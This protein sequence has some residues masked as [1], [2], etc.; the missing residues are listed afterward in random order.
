MFD[1]S[2]FYDLAYAV[3]Y[4]GIGTAVREG[5]YLLPL[6]N[7]LHIMSVVLVFGTIFIVDLRMIGIMATNRPFTKVATELL[8]W[9]W[10]GFAIALV[11]GL[12]LVAANA[13]TFLVNQEFQIK[14]VLLLLAGINMIVF[15]FIS[16]RDVE[17]WDNDRSPPF[18]V[19]LS[20][21]LSLSLWSAVIVFGRWIGYTKGW[22]FSAPVDFDL[23]NLFGAIDAIAIAAS[24]IA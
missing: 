6:I 8:K 9:T 7:A 13:T 21:F 22:N 18:K 10:L 1:L 16:I 17:K 3:E 12:L 5:I 24:A 15:E 2:A 14:M 11:T 20:G 23:D 19:R 4:S